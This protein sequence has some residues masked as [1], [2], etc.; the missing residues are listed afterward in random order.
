MGKYFDEIIA[1]LTVLFLL[2]VAF[3]PLLLMVMS[4]Q[5][6]NEIK[7]IRNLKI[8]IWVN[9]CV[10]ILYN[11]CSLLDNY[12]QTMVPGNE[13]LLSPADDNLN[14]TLPSLSD[15]NLNVTLPFLSENNISGNL[16]TPKP[17][18]APAPAPKRR[19]K[20]RPPVMP[21]TKPPNKIVTLGTLDTDQYRYINFTNGKLLLDNNANIKIAGPVV[22]AAISHCVIV[23]V[24]IGVIVYLECKKCRRDISDA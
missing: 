14:V 18:P 4:I 23:Y 3:L 7:G 11:D 1:P 12:N 6:E 20:P 15:N 8:E 5:L 10:E 2:T 17:I 16:T 21:T 19:P 9:D 13:S 22:V 24:F